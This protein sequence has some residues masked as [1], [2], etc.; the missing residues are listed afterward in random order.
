MESIR[1]GDDPLKQRESRWVFHGDGSR[2]YSLSD[3]DTEALLMT[4]APTG[5][6]GFELKPVTRSRGADGVWIY[7]G[8]LCSVISVL[9]SYLSTI[10]VLLSYL[11]I[12]SVLLSYLSIISVLLSYLSIISVLLS[13]LSIISVLLSYLSTIS[14]LLSYLSIISV[15][16]SYLSII[17][18]LPFSFLS[19]SSYSSSSFTCQGILFHALTSMT[20]CTGT[21]NPP[22]Q[23]IHSCSMNDLFWKVLCSCTVCH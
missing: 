23:V 12:I 21:W 20:H 7:L 14:V 19:A 6:A 2:C 15:L 3:G 8:I 18:V 5:A 13:Y 10:S 4:Y 11:S 1:Q 22:R 17:S 9:L 16:L